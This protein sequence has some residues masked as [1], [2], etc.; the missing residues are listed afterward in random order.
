MTAG[1]MS[2]FTAPA[3]EGLARLREAKI[4]A[5][6]LCGPRH[7]VTVALK[8]AIADP[9]AIDVA[10]DEIDALPALTRRRLLAAMAA[11]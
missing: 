11:A 7:P 4:A 9:Q 5:S 6:L 3:P 1:L 2:V 8:T 10:I